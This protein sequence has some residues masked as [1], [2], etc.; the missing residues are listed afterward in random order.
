MVTVFILGLLSGLDNLQIS[1]SI[2]LM[3]LR[4]G[5][6]WILITSF[7]LFEMT[8]PLVGLL[9]GEQV[10]STFQQ[11]AQWLGPGIMIS[12]GAYMLF[13]E[14]ME[15]EQEDIVNTNWV[16]ILLP[17]L[18]SMDNLVAG[19]GL[20]TSGYPVYSTA[21]IVGLCA[22]TMCF[23]G[24]I[25]GDRLRRFIPGKIEIAS[26]LYLIGMAVFILFND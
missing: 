22:A 11:T 3:G 6:R 2:G 1:S 23:A 12:L 19:V 21:V 15:K 10:N 20:G 18:M 24:V 13:R 9:I 8:M 4:P 26:G 7:A 16:L 14:W 5:R 25:I 17:F